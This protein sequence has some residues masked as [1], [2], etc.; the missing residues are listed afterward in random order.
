M[1]LNQLMLIIKNSACSPNKEY[2]IMLKCNFSDVKTK[3]MTHKPPSISHP[4]LIQMLP[5]RVQNE[6]FWEE[7][8]F[9]LLYTEKEV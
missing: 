9:I 8:G 6:Q 3:K 5:L 4:T 7:K 1:L 2:P